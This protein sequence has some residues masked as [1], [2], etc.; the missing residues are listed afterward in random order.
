MITAQLIGSKL[1]SIAFGGTAAS[2]PTNTG[3]FTFTAVPIGAAA[4]SRLVVIGIVSI[5][6]AAIATVTIGGI[7]AT[8]LVRAGT[9]F[10][11]EFWTAMVPTG[12]TATIVC[13]TTAALFNRVSVTTW[14]LTNLRSTTALSTA[15]SIAS[16]GS[17]S[18]TTSPRGF[19][20]ALATN[21]I[22]AGTFTWGAAGEDYQVNVSGGN[23]ITRSGYHATTGPSTLTVTYA[24]STSI[25]VMLAAS[26]R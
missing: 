11:V 23:P 5:T 6:T 8:L 13:T 17:V 7:A 21:N 22:N 14:A 2:G 18:L 20:I 3:A 19:M 25:P 4:A 26:F 12:T 15:N 9:S 24:P 1:P 16:P 10:P